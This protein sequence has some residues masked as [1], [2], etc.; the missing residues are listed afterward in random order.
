[1]RYYP[2]NAFLFWYV[3]NDMLNEFM[4]YEFLRD[5]HQIIAIFHGKINFVIIQSSFFK[6]LSGE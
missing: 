6:L 3:A 1:M 2:I 5:Y 4:F